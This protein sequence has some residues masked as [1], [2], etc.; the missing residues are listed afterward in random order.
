MRKLFPILVLTLTVLVLSGCIG[1][2][3]FDIDG[4]NLDSFNLNNFNSDCVKGSGNVV[5]ET[6][7]VSEFD[8]VSLDGTGNLFVSQGAHSVRI[9]AEDNIFEIIKIKIEG[10]KLEIEYEKCIANTKPVNIYVTA[11]NFKKFEIEEAGKLESE[12]KLS[13]TNLEIKIDG[14]ASVDLDLAIQQLI[15]DIDGSGSNIVLEGT[16]TKHVVEIDGMANINAFDLATEET[17]ITVSGT[18]SSEVNA[19]KELSV[20]ING[21]GTVIYM[22]EPEVSQTINGTGTVK[23]RT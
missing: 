2:D 3:G 17:A 18:T 15:I 23:K 7:N 16:A 8:S 5:T 1:S 14:S 19:T 6:V 4:F 12:T 10:T 20:I 9:E 21:A 13:G 22:G 11:P